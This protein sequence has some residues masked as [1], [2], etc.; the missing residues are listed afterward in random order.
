MIRNALEGFHAFIKPATKEHIDG[1]P[2]NGMFIAIPKHLRNRAK[3]ISPRSNRIQAI[4]LET[5]EGVMMIINVYFP[6]D[7]KTKKYV[8]D[9]ELEDMLVA[10]TSLIENHHCSNVVIVGDL[11]MDIKRDNGRVERLKEFLSVN[12]L[13]LAWNNFLVDFTHEF[14]S[15]GITY[16]HTLDHFIWNRN[17]SNKISEAG[18]YHSPNN[19]SDHSPIYCDI[20]QACTTDNEARCNT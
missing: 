10:I 9:T 14:E 2:A 1:R 12:N 6:A 20:E 3:D 17:F 15:E 16:T 18:V 7:P 11:N 19:T 5:N 8:F 13:E 4:L